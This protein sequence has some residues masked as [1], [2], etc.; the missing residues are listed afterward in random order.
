[1]LKARHKRKIACFGDF[2]AWRRDE[3]NWATF[4]RKNSILLR[5]RAQDA[6]TFLRSKN[7]KFC[8]PFDIVGLMLKVRHKR[9]IA[10]FGRFFG[11]PLCRWSL[12]ESECNGFGKWPWNCP[13]GGGGTH[14]GRGSKMTQKNFCSLEVGEP[15]IKFFRSSDTPILLFSA[16]EKNCPQGTYANFT[17]SFFC[18][19]PV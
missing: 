13:T 1:M 10:F 3:S 17:F 9:K 8:N 6:Q 16:S 19:F 11:C 7:K 2:L 15:Q 5:K 4:L 14:P 12:P 18:V